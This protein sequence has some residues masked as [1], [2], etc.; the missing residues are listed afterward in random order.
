MCIPGI[1][2]FM[3]LRLT[4]K[5]V[6]TL[7]FNFYSSAGEVIIVAIA[8]GSR[9]QPVSTRWD[10]LARKVNSNGFECISSAS[11]GSTRRS[12]AP[13]RHSL[14]P[15]SRLIEPRWQLATRRWKFTQGLAVPELG[16]IVQSSDPV[17]PYKYIFEAILFIYV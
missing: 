3:A 1:S 11:P 6:L 9:R 4:A 16:S 7:G 2:G 15:G 14:S 5:S 10:G 8:L 17:D 13:D 12:G